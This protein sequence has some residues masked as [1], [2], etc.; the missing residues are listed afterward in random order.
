MNTTSTSA[1][2]TWFI[3]ILF[4]FVYWY[5]LGG[6][7]GRDKGSGNVTFSSLERLLVY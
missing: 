6:W 4:W 3:F 7:G 2:S 1:E 5:R